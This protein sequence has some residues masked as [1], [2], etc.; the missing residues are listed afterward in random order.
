M[1][2]TTSSSYVTASN[3]L[4]ISITPSSSANK[5][6]IL[7][8][9]VYSYNPGNTFRFTIYRDATNLASNGFV[10]NH[11]GDKEIPMP[12]SYLDSPNTTSA[13]TYQVYVKTTGGTASFNENTISISTITALEIKG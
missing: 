13:I 9:I 12:F 4:S 1:R 3:T 8:N 11:T 6:L 2:S 7:V 10:A 5:V